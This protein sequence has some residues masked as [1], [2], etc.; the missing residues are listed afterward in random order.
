MGG[1]ERGRKREGE[2]SGNKREE[3]RDRG[4]WWGGR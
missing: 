2:V 1:R 4:G 3:G